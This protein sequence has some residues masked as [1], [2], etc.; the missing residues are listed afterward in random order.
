MQNIQIANN[1]KKLCKD[2]GISITVLQKQCGL[3]KSFIYDLEKRAA[4]PSCLKISNVA[5]YLDCSVDYLLGRTDIPNIYIQYRIEPKK[6][7]KNFSS[8]GK[9]IILPFY[10]TPSSAGTGS[11]L[12]DEIAV[13]YMNVSKTIE[14]ADAD[15]MIEVRGDSMLPKYNDGD[16]VL[17]KQS[18][19]IYENEIGVFILNG[20]SFIKKMGTGRLISLNPAYSPLELREFDSVRCVGKVIGV[21]NM[22]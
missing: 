18:E 14:T 22:Q 3:S 19:S 12:F 10:S 5:D 13:E 16:I 1:I 20:E 21:L 8:K 9:T 17:V 7:D 2:K 6:L 15:F 4:S 11:M